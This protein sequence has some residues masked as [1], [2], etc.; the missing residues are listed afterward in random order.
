M[1]MLSR[2]EWIAVGA[3]LVVIALFFLFS[4]SFNSM[5]SSPK[6]QDS[7]ST[8]TDATATPVVTSPVPGLTV[9]DSKVGE[10]TVV[11][12]AGDILTV[13]YVG[14]LADGT[15]F[16]SSLDRGQPLVFKL[17]VDP[18]IEGWQ[19]GLVGMKEGGKRRL[20]ISPSLAYGSAGV[21]G[22]IPAN[23]TLTF[24]VEL[25]KIQPGE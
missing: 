9:E 21:Q 3:A 19:K 25:H 23:A 18:V 17:G 22:V 5:I 11:A 8:T 14:T 2:N 15:K 7:V 13:D 20:V 16:D 4:G 1:K 6:P 10:G 12:T 24:D